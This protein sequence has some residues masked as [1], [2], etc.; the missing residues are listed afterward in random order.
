VLWVCSP[1]PPPPHTHTHI[2]TYTH[3]SINT[4]NDS[5]PQSTI[6]STYPLAIPPSSSSSRKHTRPPTP[7]SALVSPLLPPKRHPAIPCSRPAASRP[8]PPTVALP[9]ATARPGASRPIAR[10]MAGGR[11]QAA[12]GLRPRAARS[13]QNSTPRDLDTRKNTSRPFEPRSRGPPRPTRRETLHARKGSTSGDLRTRTGRAGGAGRAP[14]CDLGWARPNPRPDRRGQ[15]P[16]GGR[17]PTRRRPNRPRV[18]EYHISHIAAAA[19]FTPFSP[20][21]R[22]GVNCHSSS[23]RPSRPLSPPPQV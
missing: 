12:A 8:S 22:L 3:I 1:P 9:T 5:T 13:D 10:N 4:N 7:P 2:Y 21:T 20:S 16:N 17:R 11:V 14:V 23:P 19:T 15:W 6:I 18:C